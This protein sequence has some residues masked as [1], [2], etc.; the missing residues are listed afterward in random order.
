MSKLIIVIMFCFGMTLVIGKA[1][2]EDLVIRRRDVK[3]L[4][5]DCSVFSVMISENGL[6]EETLNIKSQNLNERGITKEKLCKALEKFSSAGTKIQLMV[7]GDIQADGTWSQEVVGF[8]DGDY[9]RRLSSFT[10]YE[11]LKKECGHLNRAVEVCMIRSK[12]DAA[13]VFIRSTVSIG[14]TVKYLVAQA[15]ISDSIE[16][17]WIEDGTKLEIDKSEAETMEYKTIYHNARG[18]KTEFYLRD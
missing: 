5:T 3:V 10:A 7:S 17:L 12:D 2:A 4:K 9:M 6:T 11:F 16:T 14:R 8:V 13:H 1:S 15:S 18:E